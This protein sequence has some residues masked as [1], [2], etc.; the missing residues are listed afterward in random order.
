MPV[1][2]SA[3]ICFFSV[4]KFTTIALEQ[5]FSTKIEALQILKKL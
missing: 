3:F 1:E 5:R 2:I 4:S